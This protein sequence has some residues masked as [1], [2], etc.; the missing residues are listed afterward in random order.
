MYDKYH[1]NTVTF[2]FSFLCDFPLFLLFTI[3]VGQCT[4]NI[5]ILKNI[6]KKRNEIGQIISYYTNLYFTIV[7]KSFFVVPQCVRIVRLAISF[8]KNRENADVLTS[9]A[10]YS[11]NTASNK[12]LCICTWCTLWDAYNNVFNVLLRHLFPKI[13][14]S[15]ETYVEP[16]SRFGF[17]NRT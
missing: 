3:F 17:C 10:H 11:S 5:I 9:T 6:H 12:T 16:Q 13:V 8:S 15:T 14:S 7:R 1:L 4:R 2:S